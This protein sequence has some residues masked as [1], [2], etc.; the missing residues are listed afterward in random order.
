MLSVGQ[1][2][3]TDILLKTDKTS[4]LAKLAQ[5]L[6]SSSTLGGM[7]SSQCLMTAAVPDLPRP[8]E[9]QCHLG[10]VGVTLAAPA[11]TELP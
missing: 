7:S 4:V 8:G 5:I 1:A 11:D 10:K 2:S 6:V 9:A 3:C